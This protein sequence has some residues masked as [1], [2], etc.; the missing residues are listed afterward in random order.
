MIC[1][2]CNEEMEKGV[3]QSKGRLAW[4]RDEALLPLSR[5]FQEDLIEL[6]DPQEFF[7]LYP[8]TDAYCCK[9]CKK[10]IIDYGE[11][12]R[13]SESESSD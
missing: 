13:Q 10:V 12:E 8:A 9:H 1:P 7:S 3:I 4:S 5:L 6:T 11:M 2:F